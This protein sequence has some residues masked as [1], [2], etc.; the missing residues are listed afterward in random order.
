MANVKWIRIATDI[1]NNEKIR[2]IESMPEGDTIIVIWFKLLA[3]AG[4]VND[5]GNVYFTKELPYT[6]QMLST[7]FNRP[8]TTIQLA[9]ETFTRF[10]MIEIVNDIIHISNWEKYQNIEG[11]EK[12]REQTRVRVARHRETKKLEC[13]VTSNATVTQGNETD[14]DIDKEKDIDKDNNPPYPPSGEWDA[15]KHSNIVNFEHLVETEMRDIKNK[16]LINSLREWLAYKDNKKPKSANHYQLES[17]KKLANK[18]F[19]QAK[20]Y[21]TEAVI[22]VVDGSIANNYQGITWDSLDRKTKKHGTNKSADDAWLA[23]KEGTK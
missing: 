17:I 6:D 12:I 20:V 2:L 21:G 14:I 5:N 3:I 10:G 13:N 19:E 1:F 15:S 8:L 11:L 22:D 16:E 18:F 4:T 23:G 7:V 9:I